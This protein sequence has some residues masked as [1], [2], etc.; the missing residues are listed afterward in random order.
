M[1][2]P[3][4]TTSTSI[5]PELPKGHRREHMAKKKDPPDPTTLAGRIAIA[6]LGVRG[7]SGKAP[8]QEEFAHQLGVKMMTVSR[9][10]R[11]AVDDVKTASLRKIA[12]VS[13]RS[14]EWLV[15]GE[16]SP[17]ESRV[18]PDAAP[19]A[20]IAAIV[21]AA[22]RAEELDEEHAAELRK[23]AF[24]TGMTFASAQSI[25]SLARDLW[26]LQMRKREQAREKH[27]PAEKAGYVQTGRARQGK[28]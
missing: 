3:I 13:G 2:G 27:G 1:Q 8:T 10:E 26:K 14:Y 5:D 28:R 11:G 7:P 12:E 21:E 24:S 20:E 4:D 16:T 22:I 19:S 18:V 25:G 6:R 17:P 23:A 15:N 9:W